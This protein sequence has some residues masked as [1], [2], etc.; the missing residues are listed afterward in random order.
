MDYS[1]HWQQFL[2]GNADIQGCALISLDGALI[3]EANFDGADYPELTLAPCASAL[4]IARQLARD[5]Q[6]GELR[7]CVLQGEQ[8]FVVLMP[9]LDNAVFAVLAHKHAKLGLVLLDM[10]RAIDESFGAAEPA[11]VPQPQT[12]WEFALIS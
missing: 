10:R 1:E 5:T 2:V 3:S 12:E 7:E 6:R 11:F 8:G 4:S 9:V